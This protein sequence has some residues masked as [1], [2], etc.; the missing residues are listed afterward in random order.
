MW[1]LATLRPVAT[2]GS[3]LIGATSVAFSPDGTRLMAGGDGD[4]AIKFWDVGSLQE[5]ITLKAVSANFSKPTYSP[6]GNVL[7]SLSEEGSLHLWRAPSWAE[8]AAAEARENAKIQQ[9]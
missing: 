7:G 9:P 3:F 5:L 8:I 1:E 4:E 6:D 2:L